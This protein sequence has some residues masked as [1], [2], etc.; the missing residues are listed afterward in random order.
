[1]NYLKYFNNQLSDIFDKNQNVYVYGQNVA[2]GSHLSGLTRNLKLTKSSILSNS[3]N[4]ENCLVGIG[5]GAMLRGINAVF[6]MKQ[7]DFLLLGLDHIVNTNNILRNEN[8]TGSFTIICIIEDGGY[9][10]PQSASNNLSDFS[11]FGRVD[12]FSMTNK[13]DTKIILNEN[14][15]KPGFRI[16]GISQR[17]L[18]QELIELGSYSNNVEGKF[19]QYSDGKDITIICSNFSLPY[20]NRFLEKFKNKNISA[21]LFSINTYLKFDYLDII[22]N[23]SKTKKVLIIDDSKSANLLY[24]DIINEIK[25]SIELDKSHVIKREYSNDFYFPKSDDLK[26]DYESII[27]TFF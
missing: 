14:L 15:I 2:T 3:P 18:S 16:L 12:C 7:Q 24:S 6:C 27:D 20:G 5:F 4:S 22:K 13:Y 8:L 9:E 19:F 26:I 11:S 10:G 25:E 21:S 1:M 23:V 17:L